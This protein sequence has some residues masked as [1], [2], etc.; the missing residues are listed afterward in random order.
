MT[1]PLALFLIPKMEVS[2][3][4]SLQHVSN[5]NPLQTTW[6]APASQGVTEDPKWVRPSRIRVVL[7]GANGPKSVQVE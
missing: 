2:V 4:S 1:R 7:F 5:K 3:V 6:A